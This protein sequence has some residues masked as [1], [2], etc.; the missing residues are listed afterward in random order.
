MGELSFH[1]L[2]Q[3]DQKRGVKDTSKRKKRR[4]PDWEK[5]LAPRPSDK[6]LRFRI[7][8]DLLGINKRMSDESIE[9]DLNHLRGEELNGHSVCVC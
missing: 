5:P 8:K 3:C 9:K 7:C 4:V 6:K 1:L 2:I